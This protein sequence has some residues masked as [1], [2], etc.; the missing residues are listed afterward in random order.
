MHI[1]VWLLLIARDLCRWYP[2]SLVLVLLLGAAN[3]GSL[4]LANSLIQLL[5]PDE[6]RGR[7][8]SL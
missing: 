1:I 5:V 6:L 4:T 7:V 8:M 2:F 3:N